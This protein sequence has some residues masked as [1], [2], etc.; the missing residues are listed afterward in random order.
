MKESGI[1]DE[2]G[3]KEVK[4]EDIADKAIENTELL[5]EILNGVTSKNPRVKFNSAKVL[6][7]ISEKDP[8]KLYLK[9]DFFINLLDSENNIIKWIAID[10]I[11]NLTSVD[12]KKRFDEIFRKFYDLLSDESMVTAGHVIDNSG[13]IARAKPYLRDRI[14]RE[15][16]EVEKIQC[17]TSECRNILLGKVIS[18]FSQYFDQ[19]E[20]KEEMILLAKRQRNNTRRATKAKAE[21]FLAAI[22][23]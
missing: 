9:I 13:K 17:K 19:A 8:Q 14:T 11:A 20:N 18:C 6:R 7:I 1:L 23:I 5:P 12:S 22:G 3:R 16:L 2:I 15:L 21:K 10:V 4:T